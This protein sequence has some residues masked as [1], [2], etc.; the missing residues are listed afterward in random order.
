MTDGWMAI[1]GW[2]VQSV[3]KGS[4]E[5]EREKKNDWAVQKW[6]KEDTGQMMAGWGMV[7]VMK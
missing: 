7:R 6:G 3:D 5:G 1:N 2:V 4:G